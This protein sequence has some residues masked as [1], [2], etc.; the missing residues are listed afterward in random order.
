V[1]SVSGPNGATSTTNYDTYGR[2]TN[3]TIADGAQTTYTYTYNPNTQTATLGNRWKKTTLDGF[4]RTI[5]V[6]TG[7]H[8][9]T[10]AVVDTEYAPCACA[11]LGKMRRVSQPHAPGAT[12][13]WTTYTY[14][15]SGRTLTVTAADG[16]S[17]TQYAY[18]GN[19]TT[20][21]DPAGKW[22]T[23]TNDANGNLVTVAEP[24]PQGG[25]DYVTS[26]TYNGN[27]QLRK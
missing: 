26:Y 22:K 14:D 12:P 18:Q 24:N 21:T 2:P 9:T 4:G 10:V 11:P 17:V 3:S 5:K 1:T 23:F 20:V 7:H 15:A 6:E 27:N 16:A 25:A 19:K 13:V 8:T